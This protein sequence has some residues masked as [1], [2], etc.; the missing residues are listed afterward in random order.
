M[1]RF[2]INKLIHCEPPTNAYD[3]MFNIFNSCSNEVFYIMSISLSSK[4]QTLLSG[5]QTSVWL[6][7][8]SFSIQYVNT[9]K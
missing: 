9:D 1:A 2:M 5:P 4:L 8:W 3:H 7:K 6:K